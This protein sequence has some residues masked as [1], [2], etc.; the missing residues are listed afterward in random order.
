[1]EENKK[2]GNVLTIVLVV[3]LL[4]A[5][6]VICYLLGSN[7]ANENNQN[8]SSNVSEEKENNQDS[9][10]NT[11]VEEENTIIPVSYTPKCTEVTEPL[12][13][14][15]EVTKY[16]NIVEYIQEQQNVQITLSYC[17][18]SDSIEG[19]NYTLTDSEKNMALNEIK[20]S[21]YYME[22]GGVGGGACVPDVYINYERNNTQYVLKYWGHV[23]SSDD[24]NIYKILDESMNETQYN[25]PCAY[26]TDTLGSTINDIIK[27][28]R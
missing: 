16:N 22:T 7:N 1:M 12:V 19:V 13:T 24:G 18:D 21:N 26:M 17:K 10:N 15:I 11:N 8:N 20:N 23:M 27:Y 5:V 14:D 28:E 25:S 6:G 9:G 3:L 4:I 2:R